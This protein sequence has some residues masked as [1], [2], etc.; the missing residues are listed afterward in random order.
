MGERMGLVEILRHWTSMGYQVSVRSTY[1][2]TDGRARGWVVDIAG[3]EWRGH[4][5][6]LE[7]LATSAHERSAAKTRGE[8]DNESNTDTV[9][10]TQSTNVHTTE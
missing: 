5:D 7:K 10:G 3:V 6:D 4:L 9:K 2:T 1:S 8:R